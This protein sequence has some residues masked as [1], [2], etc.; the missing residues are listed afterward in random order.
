MQRVGTIST[1]RS[2]VPRASPGRPAPAIR[3][4]VAITFKQLV[5][6]SERDRPGR[7]C[8]VGLDCACMRVHV[9]LTRGPDWRCICPGGVGVRN[10]TATR[11]RRHVRTH[12]STDRCSRS[13]DDRLFRPRSRVSSTVLGKRTLAACCCFS[14]GGIAKL[15]F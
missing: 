7:V 14:M 9:K 8:C 10:T 11:R 6:C 5:C 15:F 3:H 2:I 1:R 12:Q 13:T 4:V